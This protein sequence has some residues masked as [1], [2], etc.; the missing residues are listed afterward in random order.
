MAAEGLKPSPL[1]L[2]MHPEYGLWHGYRGAIL[3]GEAGIDNATG[4]PADLLD[5]WRRHISEPTRPYE[6]A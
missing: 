4:A 6:E 1:G 2:L 5:L 3:F